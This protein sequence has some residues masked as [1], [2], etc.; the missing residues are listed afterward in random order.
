MY[1]QKQ[2]KACGYRLMCCRT[3]M[4]E[5]RL[6]GCI[7]AISGSSSMPCLKN[8]LDSFLRIREKHGIILRRE[9]I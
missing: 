4:K 2:E 9:L 6:G 5:V 1:T 7:E 8:H 3:D